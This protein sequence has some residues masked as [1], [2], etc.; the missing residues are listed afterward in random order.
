MFG[1]FLNGGQICS[2]TTRLLIEESIS[3]EVLTKLKQEAGMVTPWSTLCKTLADE[4]T[5][6]STNPWDSLDNAFLCVFCRQ[7]VF[8]FADGQSQPRKTRHVSRVVVHASSVCLS[9]YLFVYLLCAFVCLC[10]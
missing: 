7:G 8:G 1:C 10:D 2:A 4:D 6:L 5:E 3:A 9:D